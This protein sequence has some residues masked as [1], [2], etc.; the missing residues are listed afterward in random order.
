MYDQIYYVNVIIFNCIREQ[1]FI[2]SVHHYEANT[3]YTVAREEKHHP[4]FFFAWMLPRLLI[5]CSPGANTVFVTPLPSQHLQT[6]VTFL[7][8]VLSNL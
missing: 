3:L 2:T 4:F 8:S 6:Q 1:T 7:S 5:W